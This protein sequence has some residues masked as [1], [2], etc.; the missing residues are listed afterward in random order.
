M[1]CE[2]IALDTLSRDGYEQNEFSIESE[3][4]WKNLKGIHYS[5]AIISAVASQINGVSIV[6]SVVCSGAYQ[7]KHQSS[8]S[9]T[10]VT[11]GFPSQT[12]NNAENVLI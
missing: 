8:A 7:I 4:Q 6:C 12:A 3:I 9:L 5:D 1:T 2:K 11:S 10:F